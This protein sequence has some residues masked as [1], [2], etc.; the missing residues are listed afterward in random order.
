MFSI[1]GSGFPIRLR[2][3]ILATDYVEDLVKTSSS[4]VFSL[5]GNLIAFPNPLINVVGYFLP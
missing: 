2:H 4:W 5:S 3:N 1:L